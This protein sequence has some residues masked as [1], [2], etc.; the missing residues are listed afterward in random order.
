MG[1]VL[2]CPVGRRQALNSY[3]FQQTKALRNFLQGFFYSP[4]SGRR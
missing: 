3:R 1:R 2:L 4:L